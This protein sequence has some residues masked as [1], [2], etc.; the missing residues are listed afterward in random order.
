MSDPQH[1]PPLSVV[2]PAYN[3]ER[4]IERA[5]QSILNQITQDPL[6]HHVRVRNTTCKLNQPRSFRKR[7]EFIQTSGNSHAKS[8]GG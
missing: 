8:S 1:T 5:I 7:H 4:Y 6:P 3:A 2:M